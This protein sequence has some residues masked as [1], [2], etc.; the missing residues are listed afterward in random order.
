MDT[1]RLAKQDLK[2]AIKNAKEVY[3]ARLERDSGTNDPVVDPSPGLTD[4]LN[5]F[6]TRFERPPES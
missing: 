5:T 2:K 6:Y 3:R 4:D 1:F